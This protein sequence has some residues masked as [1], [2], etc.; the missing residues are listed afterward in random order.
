MTVKALFIKM[1]I[2]LFALSLFCIN[3]CN[4]DQSPT[5]PSPP[6]DDL[7]AYISIPGSNLKSMLPDPVR[8][9][10]YITDTYQNCVYFVN[11]STNV[12]ED[13]LVIGSSPTLMDISEDHSLL[14][15]VLSGAAQVGIIDLTQKWVLHPID[16]PDWPVNS[17][18]AGA[19]NKLYIG[20]GQP[21]MSPSI[22]IFDIS[23]ND[24]DHLGI[25]DSVTI[26][27][28]HIAGRSHDRNILYTQQYLY[29]NPVVIQWDISGP[30]PE[31]IHSSH[32][33]GN[34]NIDPGIV[35]SLPGD[36]SICILGTGSANHDGVI[37]VHRSS[38][39]LRTGQFNVEWDPISIAP[40][41]IGDRV[42][43]AHGLWVTNAIEPV[44][45]RHDRERKDLHIFNT[46]TYA[47]VGYFTLREYVEKNG[48]VVTSDD[49]IYL[50]LGR[51]DAKID[52]IGVISP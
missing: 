3:S 9:L 23:T 25:L 34:S 7:D 47:E 35:K 22:Q 10:V 33:F 49:Q 28:G 12:V 11:T 52:A 39:I 46:S 1:N 50:L 30:V 43:V 15:V 4:N 48:I 32:L 36:E 13:S 51:E 31:K 42:Y 40:N 14:F 41:L 44:D 6:Q 5:N 24:R 18:A 17:V 26:D 21:G 8:P 16:T 29:T 45:K 27:L 19:N 2:L 38:D 37:P 20:M